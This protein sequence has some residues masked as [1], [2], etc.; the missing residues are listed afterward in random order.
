MHDLHPNQWPH[1]AASDS[2]LSGAHKSAAERGA[3][4]DI[5]ALRLRMMKRGRWLEIACNA[6]LVAL[7]IVSVALVVSM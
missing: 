5:D 3:A 6:T 7:A 4:A 2:S 1:V